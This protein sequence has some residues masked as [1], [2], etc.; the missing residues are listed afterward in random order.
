MGQARQSATGQRQ[1][2]IDRWNLEKGNAGT[3]GDSSL[4]RRVICPKCIGTGLGLGLGLGL[5][6]ELG[7]GLASNFGIRTTPFRTNDPSDN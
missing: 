2:Y 1:K 6:L 5:R 7:L 4:V 3:D